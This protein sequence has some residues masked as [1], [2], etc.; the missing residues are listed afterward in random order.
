MSLK[1]VLD[2]LNETSNISRINAKSKYKDNNDFAKHQEKYSNIVNANIDSLILPLIEKINILGCKTF[3]CCQGTPENSK[4]LYEDAF[5]ILERK[6]F[7]LCKSLFSFDYKLEIGTGGYM[8]NDYWGDSISKNEKDY[9]TI[10]FNPK[11]L[12]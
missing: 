3:E 1:S 6:N 5:I 12:K 9:I 7:N 11:Y 10:F 4:Y 8:L 2:T